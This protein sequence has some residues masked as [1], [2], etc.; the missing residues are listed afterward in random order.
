MNYTP[1][2]YEELEIQLRLQFRARP[3]LFAKAASTV[4]EATGYPVEYPTD[5]LELVAHAW[6]ADYTNCVGTPETREQV[7][8]ALQEI[9]TTITNYQS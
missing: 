9:I 2:S 1:S 7:V 8:G 6:V 4:L 3:E 5:S